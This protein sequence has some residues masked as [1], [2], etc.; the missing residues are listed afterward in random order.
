M[1]ILG[2]GQSLSSVASPTHGFP[3]CSADVAS[4]LVLEMVLSSWPSYSSLQGTQLL[5]QALQLSAQTLHLLQLSH[6]QSTEGNIYSMVELLQ[7][8]SIL[9]W[10]TVY[11]TS[12]DTSSLL[13][14]DISF[15]L[16][17]AT[18]MESFRRI[19]LRILKGVIYPCKVGC[20]AWELFLAVRFAAVRITIFKDGDL[21]DIRV[22][23][24][25][26]RVLA[27][28]VALCYFLR[29]DTLACDEDQGN[30]DHKL[31]LADK[32]WS[33]IE[34]DHPLI[35]ANCWKVQVQGSAKR[36]TLG[37]VNTVS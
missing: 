8:D 11:S 20:C 30:Q 25:E 2:Q 29:V 14:V 10:L 19:S 6:A 1:I 9:T 7:Q 35:N 22:W 18:I 31:H 4:T 15:F 32:N 27:V 36:W 28:A 34:A 17:P 24:V 37:C 33:E 12:G 21:I 26:S 16:T 5:A 13:A 3:P 23:V